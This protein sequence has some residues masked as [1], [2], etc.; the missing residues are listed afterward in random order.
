MS[1]SILLASDLGPYNDQ[2]MVQ[3]SMFAQEQQGDL[4]ILHVVEPDKA[5]AGM[6]V[7]NYL[8]T[9]LEHYS[10]LADLE[11]LADSVT[12][13]IKTAVGDLACVATKIDVRIGDVGP[14]IVAQAIARNV[15]L[16]VMGRQLSASGTTLDYV[17]REAKVP[18]L[19]L[20]VT[21]DK[22]H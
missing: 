21:I 7:G 10:A 1:S 16:I 8:S 6:V 5:V 12:S 18:V 4:N 13:Q 9:Q 17:L 2:I 3:A 14:T 22:I 20:P 15:D 19:V 11:F